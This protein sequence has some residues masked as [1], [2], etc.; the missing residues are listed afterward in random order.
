MIGLDT[1]VIVRYLAQ[2]DPVQS[3]VAAD[4][5]ERR[6]TVERPGFVSLVAMVETVWVLDRVYGLDAAGL[7]GVVERLLAADALVVE[8]EPEVYT[9]MEAVREGIGSFA[10]ALVAALGARAGCVHTL[11]FDRQALRLPGFQAAEAGRV[12]P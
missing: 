6:L 1:N 8:C 2:D 9:A 5:F 12:S 11:T 3:A 10:D 4:I 7:V